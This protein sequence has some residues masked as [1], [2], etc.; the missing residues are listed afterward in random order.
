[1]RDGPPAGETATACGV[2]GP[3]RRLFCW[4]LSWEDERPLDNGP[5]DGLVAGKSM[6]ITTMLV[7]TAGWRARSERFRAQPWAR[8]T[9]DG[10]GSH[11]RTRIGPKDPGGT[12]LW[13]APRRRPD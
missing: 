4:I 5:T 12:A 13:V 7:G 1:M 10:A 9:W 3:A 11:L 8:T 6:K 2:T